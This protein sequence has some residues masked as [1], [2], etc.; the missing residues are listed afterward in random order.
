MT[1]EVAHE[2]YVHEYLNEQKWNEGKIP[3]V[4]VVSPNKT[5]SGFKPE[6]VD[7]SEYDG[8]VRL[9]E[10][11]RMLGKMKTVDGSSMGRDAWSRGEDGRLARMRTQVRNAVRTIIQRENITSMR[12][13]LEYKGGV[14]Y[15]KM[16]RDVGL[17]LGRPLE[18]TEKAGI[19]DTI[20]NMSWWRED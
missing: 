18:G 4:K 2:K 1:K 7:D 12:R 3:K 17:V 16:Y 19:R 15:A 13:F 20:H 6:T 11:R 5:T 10:Y 14:S 8:G 9:G